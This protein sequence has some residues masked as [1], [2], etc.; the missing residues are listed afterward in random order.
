MRSSTLVS[1]AFAASLLS[2]GFASAGCFFGLCGGRSAEVDIEIE[3]D[4]DLVLPFVTRRTES[5][6]LDLDLD[7]DVLV[8]RRFDSDSDL[9]ADADCGKSNTDAD[10]DSDAAT[11]ATAVVTALRGAGIVSGATQ[12]SEDTT[13]RKQVI[14]EF[15]GIHSELNDLRRDVDKANGVAP[16]PVSQGDMADVLNELRSE[17]SKVRADLDEIKS[18]QKR[19]RNKVGLTDPVSGSPAGGAAP[20]TNV[21]D[22]Q[23]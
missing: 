21:P 15:R 19:I 1:A 9:S 5:D 2:P 23:D 6:L 22:F 8:V 3:G 16:R 18:E 14:E 4:S 12:E 7:R 10:T 11:I 20:V 13:F 17:M